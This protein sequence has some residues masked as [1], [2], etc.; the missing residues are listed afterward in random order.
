M[1]TAQI[2]ETISDKEFR[3]KNQPLGSMKMRLE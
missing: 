3:W 2:Y 1:D